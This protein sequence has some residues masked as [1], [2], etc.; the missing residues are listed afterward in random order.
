MARYTRSTMMIGLATAPALPASSMLMR[1]RWCSV[2]TRMAMT[3]AT[4]STRPFNPEDASPDDWAIV[5]SVLGKFAAP[6][7]VD[8]LSE[9]LAKRRAGLHIVLE[10]VENPYDVAAIMRTAEGLGVHHLH[11]VNTQRMEHVIPTP[12]H[13]E[14]DATDD[15]TRKSF[16]ATSRAAGNRRVS[17]RALGNVAMGAARWL[18][19]RRYR[20][21]AECY[22]ALKNDYASEVRILASTPAP[23]FDLGDRVSQLDRTTSLG[24]SGPPIK[25]WRKALTAARPLDACLAELAAANDASGVASSDAGGAIALVFGEDGKLSRKALEHA[26]ESF[27]LPGVVGLTKTFS[28]SLTMAMSVYAVLSSGVAPEG[29]LSEAE[30][31]EM[32]GRWLLRDVRA[33][34]QI[35]QKEAHLEYIKE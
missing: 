10:N 20:N 4:P 5:S 15:S 8:R 30:R 13:G 23:Q 6:E 35:L 32:M 34:K 3:S 18:T 11:C 21:T 1:P 9:V 31:T 27:H 17:K 26:D 22:T 12:E 25:H 33:A 16:R 2:R 28:L 29:T 19:V 14:E 7:R 24:S